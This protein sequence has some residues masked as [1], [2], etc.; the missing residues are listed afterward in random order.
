MVQDNFIIKCDG[1]G[2]KNKIPK[3]RLNDRPK[4]GKCGKGLTAS[5]VSDR[6]VDITDRTFQDEILKHPGPILLDCWAPWCGPC[7]MV[8]PVLEELASEYAGRV[9]IAKLNVDE[10]P[11]TASKYAIQS[12]PTML[13][14][15]NGKE[16]DKVVGALPKSEIEQH[17]KP[18]I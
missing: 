1:C 6:P 5:G 9:K 3:S 12:I 11:A 15:K 13:F 8:A 18:L 2:T 14:F 10:N 16:V 7:K 4:C 17:L